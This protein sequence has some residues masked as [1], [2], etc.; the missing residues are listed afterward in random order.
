MI[1]A[2]FLVGCAFALFGVYFFGVG[3]RHFRQ[4]QR[5]RQ[6]PVLEGRIES[7]WL[8]GRRMIDG[9]MKPAEHLDVTYSFDYGG[10]SWQS[11]RIAFYT[12]V[13]PETW[14]L[15]EQFSENAAVSVSVNPHQPEESVLIPGPRPGHKRY[16]DI[17]LA[18]IAMVVGVGLAWAGWVSLLGH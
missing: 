15:A 16:S 14:Q 11:Q 18:V 13:Y 9:E 4:A 17:I 6:W 3:V 2:P 8:W 1:N 10:Q 7:S 12:L 5:S